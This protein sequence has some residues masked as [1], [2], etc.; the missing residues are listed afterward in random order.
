[1]FD[2]GNLPDSFV[3]ALRQATWLLVT[4]GFGLIILGLL[5]WVQPQLLQFL[6]GLA[7]IVAGAVLAAVAWKTRQVGRGF[8]RWRDGP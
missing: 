2:R 4:P 3:R 5:I 6:V 8:D 7:L 1:M